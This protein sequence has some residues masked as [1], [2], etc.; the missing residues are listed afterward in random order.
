MAGKTFLDGSVLG[1][2]RSKYPGVS[3]QQKTSGALMQVTTLRQQL[4]HFAHVLQSSLF[5]VL[6][7]EIGP[8]GSKAAL[9]VKVLAMAPLGPWLGPR[10]RL[11]RPRQHR[12]ALAAAFIAKAV[13]NLTTTRN[14]ME[15]LRNNSQVRRLCGWNQCSRLPHESTFSRAFAEFAATELPQK[16]HEALIQA[17]QKGRLIG[18]ISRDSTAIAARER[19]P[20]P[21]S[22]PRKKKRGPKPKRAKLTERGTLIERQPHM[23]LP[24][25]LAGLSRRCAIGVKQSPDGRSRYW[26]GYK[27]HTDVADGQIPISAVL[28]GANVH[29]VNVAI[30]LM[31]MTANRVTWLYDLMDSAYDA[32][33]VLEHSRAMDHVAIVTP[34]PRRNGRSQSILPNVFTA[35]RAPELTWAQQDRFRERTTVERVYARLK[36][37]FGGRNLRVRGAAKVMAHLMFGILALTADQVLKLT[38]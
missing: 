4:L 28:T 29:D 14:L 35:K 13:F 21:P 12:C 32:D 26:R 8:L 30:P 27:L 11:G 20:D 25:M 31:T 15:E 6:E 1:G 34:H 2:A 17:T 33:A 18:H 7:E 16:L 37:E 10:K 5:P 23:T 3:T 9:L 24:T 22:E 36:D 19:F 38:G